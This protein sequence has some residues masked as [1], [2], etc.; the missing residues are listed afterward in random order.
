MTRRPST[1]RQVVAGAASSLWLVLGLFFVSGCS[2][3]SS[4]A[5]SPSSVDQPAKVEKNASTGIAKITLSE[6]AISRLDLKTATVQ[7]GSG[8]TTITLPYEALLYDAH[9]ATWVYTNP[10]PRVYQRHPVAV[11]R[12]EGATVLAS[13]GPPVGTVIVTTAAAELFG[14]EFDTAH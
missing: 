2:Q 11:T 10:E 4:V 8:G 5:S 1:G 6:K 9:G 12:V 13:A 7:P 3:T 14:A